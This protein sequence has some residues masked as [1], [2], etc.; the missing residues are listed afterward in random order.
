MKGYRARHMN[1][2]VP[3]P[4]DP[5]PVLRL[6][7]D[8]L[9]RR[10][11]ARVT[12]FVRRMG[13]RAD[14]QVED[15]VQSVFQQAHKTLERLPEKV[16]VA[17]EAQPETWLYKITLNVVLAEKRRRREDP[18]E[19][20]AV[21]ELMSSTPGPEELLERGRART[22][23]QAVLDALDI[24]DRTVLVLRELEGLSC[25]EI[26]VVLGIPIGT[27]WS[28]LSAARREFRKRYGDSDHE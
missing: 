22:R 5:K 11:A 19:E 9:F 16:F 2:P 14:A 3:P 23:I 20:G 18:A 4:D 6:D 21:A 24:E 25:E 28:R 13:V 12:A 10:Y 15:H 27:V 26:A 8:Q 7:S 1:D 17:D